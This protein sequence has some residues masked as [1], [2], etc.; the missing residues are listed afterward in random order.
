MNSEHIPKSHS[1]PLSVNNLTLNEAAKINK[2]GRIKIQQSYWNLR[3]KMIH[4]QRTFL[5][6]S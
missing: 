6:F 3:Q 1:P 5:N 2:P 4:K